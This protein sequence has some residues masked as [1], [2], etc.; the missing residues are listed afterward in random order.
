MRF[1]IASFLG[2]EAQ[3][4][5]IAPSV[6]LRVAARDSFGFIG[7][8]DATEGTTR[9]RTDRSLA[10]AAGRDLRHGAPAGETGADHRLVLPRAEVRRGLR[11]QAKPAAAADAADGGIG[12]PQA[13]PRSVR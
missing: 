3:K 9:Q 6:F 8:D 7:G 11:G 10:L 13:H 1:E 2:L 4:L 12:H 5:A